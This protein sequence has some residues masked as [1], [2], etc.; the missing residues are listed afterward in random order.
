MPRSPRF[1]GDVRTIV[2]YHMYQN[3]CDL[4]ETEIVIAHGVK[5]LNLTV[6][7]KLLKT[8][9]NI[10]TKAAS[11][12]S[13][14]RCRLGILPSMSSAEHLPA[15]SYKNTKNTHITAIVD[16]PSLAWHVVEVSYDNICVL[17][18]YILLIRQSVGQFDS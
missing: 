4:A 7:E 18:L 17:F 13:F 11:S 16:P 14:L 3:H 2:S 6:P 1:K 10:L 15:S 12:P 8:Y 9:E 5:R